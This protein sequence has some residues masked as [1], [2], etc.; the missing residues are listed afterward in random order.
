MPIASVADRLE[1]IR[2]RAV[3][4]LVRVL[5]F[6][7][8][9]VGVFLLFEWPPLVKS[10]VAA[11]LIAAQGLSVGVAIAALLL[12]PSNPAHPDAA[13]VRILPVSDAAARFWFGKLAALTGLLSLGL[14]VGGA[15]KRLGFTSDSVLAMSYLF[16]VGLAAVFLLAVWRTPEPMGR[17]RDERR[18]WLLTLFVLLLLAFWAIAA[19]FLFWLTMLLGALPV[20]IWLSESAVRH[21]VRPVGE[22]DRA[23]PGLLT[24]AVQRGIRTVVLLAGLIVLEREIPSA[25]G[26]G[27][28][29]SKSCRASSRRS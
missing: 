6:F 5:A 1:A 10:T 12:A 17:P 4:L 29:S 14:M 7:A 2:G 23:G 27:G 16:A 8:G 24:A 18:T 15:M 19:D 25:F 21:V 20:V 13:A 22:G 28:N 26:I 9:S 3:V 11:A